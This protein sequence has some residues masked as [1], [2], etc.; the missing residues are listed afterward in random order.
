MLCKCFNKVL[1]TKIK[2]VNHT[3]PEMLAERL[4]I[5]K[6]YRNIQVLLKMNFKSVLKR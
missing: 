3:S 6:F 5:K 2:N 4:H 1:L